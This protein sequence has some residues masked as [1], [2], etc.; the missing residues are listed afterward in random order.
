MSKKLCASSAFSS[1][2]NKV[3]W[4]LWE[5]S[6]HW[7]TLPSAELPGSR[8]SLELHIY[9][10]SSRCHDI[11]GCSWNSAPYLEHTFQLR[12]L[13][14][15]TSPASWKHNSGSCPSHLGGCPAEQTSPLWCRRSPST[16]GF[17]S[18]AGSSGSWSEPGSLWVLRQWPDPETQWV[19]DEG[20]HGKDWST[21]S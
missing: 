12:L 6:L 20:E 1:S 8:C 14:C 11:P 2:L 17:H 15:Q 9:T 21:F 4:S 16:S 7:R 19:H 10:Q 5:N 3:T 13:F 18:S